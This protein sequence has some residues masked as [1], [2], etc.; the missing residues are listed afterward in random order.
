MGKK[1]GVEGD[2]LAT[3]GTSPYPP[4]DNGAW[5][6]GKVSETSC[7]TV[8][9]GG[10]KGLLKA[11]CTFNFTGTQTTPN[12]PVPVSGSETVTLEA[13]A[14]T[15]TSAGKVLLLDGEEQ[16]GNY[17]NKLKVVASQQKLTTS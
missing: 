3:P 16:A 2:V 7:A 15:L 12:G 1:I 4:A 11:T 8:A 13:K 10:K 5:A 17:G 9:S 6:P 14:S